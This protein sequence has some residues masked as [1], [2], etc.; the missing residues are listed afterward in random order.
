M[1]FNKINDVTNWVTKKDV[2][3]IHRQHLF[4]YAL[5]SKT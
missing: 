4:E 5:F 3:C 1:S 2:A